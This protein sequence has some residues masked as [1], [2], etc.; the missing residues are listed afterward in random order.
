MTT[1]QLS[2]LLKDKQTELSQRITAIEADFKKGRSA[3]FSEQTTECENDEV[4]D[5]IHHEA[6][7]E[8]S[9]V[10]QAIKR[11]EDGNYGICQQCDEQ[12]NPDRLEALPY[13]TTCID[14]AK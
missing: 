2:T 8:L 12:I 13:T 11:I 6:K 9:L 5:G 14:C 3:D 4:L 1:D 7:R 10:T